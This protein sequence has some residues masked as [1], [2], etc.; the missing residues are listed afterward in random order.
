MC[1]LDGAGA[2]RLC[3]HSL[4]ATILCHSR[5]PTAEAVG[6]SLSSSDITNDADAITTC[7]HM[8]AT[9]SPR[10]SASRGR[11]TLRWSGNDIT[12]VVPVRITL[13]LALVRDL[14]AIAF[15]QPADAI[16]PQAST[17]I[18]ARAKPHAVTD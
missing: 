8:G 9:R 5:I 3:D 10:C 16:T 2:A 13:I 15:Y 14:R 12:G 4:P 1:D 7:V 17:L 18:S 11:S 6:L